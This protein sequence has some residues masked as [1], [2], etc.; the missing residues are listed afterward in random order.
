MLVQRQ[1]WAEDFGLDGEVIKNLYSNL[2]QY[3][4]AEELKSVQQK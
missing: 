2:V 3:F 1:Q 4:I